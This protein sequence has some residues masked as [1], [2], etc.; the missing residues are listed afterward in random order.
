MQLLSILALFAL[1]QGTFARSLCKVGQRYCGSA[2]KQFDNAGEF[3]LNDNQLYLCRTFEGFTDGTFERPRTFYNQPVMVQTCP[4]SCHVEGSGKDDYCT[5]EKLFDNNETND[6]LAKCA[7]HQY[8]KT[9]KFAS[10][11]KSKLEVLSLEK[12]LYDGL[13]GCVYTI[14][15]PKTL[16]NT[17]K[18]YNRQVDELLTSL[19][20]G[21]KNAKDAFEAEEAKEGKEGDGN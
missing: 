14:A 20:E 2:F 19:H 11:A 12:S 9:A 18:E 8:K 16:G 1:T 5:G 15:K 4:K 3:K 13:L 7:D 21:Q 6:N 17:D 10:K